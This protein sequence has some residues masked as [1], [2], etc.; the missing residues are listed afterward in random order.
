[1]HLGD[2]LVVE[3]HAEPA[4]QPLHD[5]EQHGRG[6]EGLA[7]PPSTDVDR[8]AE[9]AAWGRAAAADLVAAILEDREPET[10]MYAGRTTLEMTTAVFAASLSG[11]RVAI[12]L[13]DR[14]SPLG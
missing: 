6:A 9:R 10:G 7:S 2:R 14:N 12:P 1:V 5:H 3:E 11:M 8:D 13:T 4:E